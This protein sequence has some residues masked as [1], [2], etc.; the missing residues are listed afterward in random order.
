MRLRL[1]VVSLV[2]VV[3]LLN[4]PLRAHHGYGAYYSPTERT[5]KVEGDLVNI[6][7]TNPHVA[8]KVRDASAT[9]YTVLWQ[10]PFQLERTRVTSTTLKP[11]DRL[12]ITSAA[13]RDPQSREL[14]LIRE[15]AR[16]S[17]GWIWRAPVAF[18]PPTT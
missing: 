17:D 14:M 10:A 2:G 4:A 1:T 6:D 16:P 5:I 12:V 9:M 18:A 7:W 15:V 3:L 13:P 8:M 11:G